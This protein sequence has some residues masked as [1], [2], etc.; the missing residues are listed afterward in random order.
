MIRGSPIGA[1]ATTRRPL[2]K[3]PLHDADF[4]AINPFSRYPLTS[5]ADTVIRSNAQGIWNRR[6]WRGLIDVESRADTQPAQQAIR[7]VITDDPNAVD[8]IAEQW[9]YLTRFITCR[10]NHSLERANAS[11]LF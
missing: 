11:L 3:L 2:P 10:G 5:L 6:L 4:L 7:T 1:T 8:A 9:L